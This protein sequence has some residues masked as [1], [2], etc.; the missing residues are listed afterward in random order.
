METII[1][2][3]IDNSNSMGKATVFDNPQQYLLP[4][5]NTRM[6]LAKKILL[7]EIIP[8]LNYASKII[9]RTFHS[10]VYKDRPH[11]LIPR[12]I[13]EG[14]YDKQILSDKIKAIND[15][16]KSGGTPIT[17]IIKLAIKKLKNHP[18][19]DRKVIL[20]TDGEETGSGD[21]KI[22]AK[23]AIDLYGIPCNIH[24]IGIAQDATA[25]LKAQALAKETDGSFI[26]LESNVYNSD[27]LQSK[28]RP[29][30]NKMIEQSVHNITHTTIKTV[31][32]TNSNS[33]KNEAPIQEEKSI[34]E[35][36]NETPNVT[37]EIVQEPTKGYSDLEKII[38][39]NALSL[40]LISKQITSLQEEIREIKSKS[41][42]HEEGE[43]ISIRENEVEQKRVGRKCEEY[44]YKILSAKYGNRLK[45]LNETE[46]LF[47]NH[48][49]E[50]LDIDNSL[51][52]YI[53]CKGSKYSDNYFF[54][55]NS[56]WH[57]FLSNTKNYQLYFI[58]SIDNNPQLIKI[59]NLLDW[60]L[61]GK[62]VPYSDK[63]R[64][65]KKGRIVLSI[66][67]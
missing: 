28:L 67:D 23:Q 65:V 1:E 64:V 21:Y 40:T 14:I 4:D 19:S 38:Q 8:N 52:Y 13:Y 43:E 58:K 5:G 37:E 63:N 16:H 36:S 6:S 62:I 29:L 50:V 34:K 53:E 61:K 9:I 56:E 44:L 42:T 26:N 30:Q 45:W 59:D 48:D 17:D 32:S 51:E 54:L 3:L 35:T 18:N 47:D 49:F 39:N 46:E 27:E 41:E 60:I 22:A 31:T 12:L 7:E 20:V 11:V 25:V 2:I 57:F 10:L 24:I 33:P 55:T 15:P 66:K